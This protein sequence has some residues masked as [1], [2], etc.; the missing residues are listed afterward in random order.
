[1]TFPLDRIRR[2]Q[3]QRIDALSRIP[4]EPSDYCAKWVP[5]F[6]GKNP[7]ERGYRAACLR[8]LARV[9]GFQ[10]STINNWGTHFEKRPDH[11]LYLLRWV[12]IVNQ[13]RQAVLLPPDIP[14]E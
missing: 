13:V 5:A 7:G 14:Q 1:M 8:E 6:H 2:K 11:F 4:L 12:D 10:E 3:Y 9:S